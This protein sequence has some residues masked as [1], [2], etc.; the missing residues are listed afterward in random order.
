MCATI[1]PEAQP[2]LFILAKESLADPL[3]FEPKRGQVQLSNSPALVLVHGTN[4]S[5]S[6]GVI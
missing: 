3:G 5:F 2:I 6:K 4:K 1:S